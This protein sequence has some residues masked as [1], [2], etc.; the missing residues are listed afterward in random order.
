MPRPVR[1]IERK[2]EAAALYTSKKTI[3]AMLLIL[4]LFTAFY[5]FRGDYTLTPSFSDGVFTLDGPQGLVYTARY[6]DIASLRLCEDME[7]GQAL[8]GGKNYG[9]LYGIYRSDELGEYVLC[10]MSKL[11]D[12]LVVTDRDGSTLA[13]TA[14]NNEA[15]R[16]LYEAFLALLHEEGFDPET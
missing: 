12:D 10:S 7:L 3:A 15:T 13:F 11:H 4:V 14:D 9:Y 6:E 8:S 1:G 5:L 16:N 2:K